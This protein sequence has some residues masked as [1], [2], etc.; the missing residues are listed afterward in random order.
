MMIRWLSQQCVWRPLDFVRA[1]V[2]EL[3]KENKKLKDRLGSFCW[4]VDQ[5]PG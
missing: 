3:K 2:S 1:K 4:N 5:V